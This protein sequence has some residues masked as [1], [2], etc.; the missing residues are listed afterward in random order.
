MKEQDFNKEFNSGYILRKHNKELAIK[1]EKAMKEGASD[2]DKGFV[3][4]MKEQEREEMEK[5]LTKDRNYKPKNFQTEMDRN[6]DKG[7][8]ME[9]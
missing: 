4:G 8:D 5:Y 6:K 7:M 3:A 1:L 2:R 9:R